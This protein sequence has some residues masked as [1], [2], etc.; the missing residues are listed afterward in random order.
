ME[1]SYAK[2]KHYYDQFD[3]WSRLDSDAGLIEAQEVTFQ[4]SQHIERGSLILDLGSGPGR[5]ALEFVKMGYHVDL[6]DLSDRLMQQAKDQFK[7]L[8]YEARIGQFRVLNAIDLSPI[9]EDTYDSIFCCGPFYHLPREI[10]RK[11]AAREIMRVCKP[12]GTVMVGF[13]PRFTGLAGLISRAFHKPDQVKE[14]TFQLM[15][16]SG[17]FENESYEGFQEGYCPTVASFKDFW[18]G[19]GLRDIEIFSTRGFMHQNEKSVIAI[20]ERDPELYNCIIEIHRKF[21]RYEPYIE[22]GGHAILTGKRL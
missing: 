18:N 22:A 11:K 10:D 1:N 17:I 16:E 5:Y 21:C 14:H 15:G 20:K 12:G 7:Y 19:I 9:Q 3:E 13:I 8:G 6:V 4:V 2:I